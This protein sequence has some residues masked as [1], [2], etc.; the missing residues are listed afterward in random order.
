MTLTYGS[1][2]S[3][4]EAASLA[5]QPLGWRCAF[6]SE[7]DKAPSA[8]LAQRFPDVPNFGDM[9]K[10][11]EWPD[12]AI[13]LLAGGTPC[14]AFSV[15]G[16][17]KGLA[18]PRGSLML[19]Y[20]AIAARY[21]PTWLVWENVPGVL[22]DDEGRSFG[23]FL[24]LLSGQSIKPPANGW[25]NSGIIAP[26]TPDAYGLAYA[27]LDAQYFRVAQRRARVFVVGYLGDWRPPLAVLLE[28]ES[29]RGDSPPRREAQQGIAGTIAGGARG[30]GGYSDDD[31][32][33]VARALTAHP[34]RID[35]ESETFITHALTG[36]GFDASEDGTGRGTP[37]V[38]VAYGIDSDCFDR[39]GEGSA[40]DAG[41]R[42]GLGIQAELSS[43]VRAKRPNAVAY[44]ITPSQSNKDYKARPTQR[45]QAITT[46]GNRPSARGGDVIAFSCKDHGADAGDL[47]PTLRAMGHDGSHANAG[48]QAAV[49]F[50][51]SRDGGAW[52][53]GDM[54]GTLDT[55][56]D[57]NSHIVQT[58]WAVRRLTPL[59]CE[60]LQG[61]PDDWTNIAYRGKNTIADGPR[62]KMIGNSWAVPVVRWIGNRIAQVDA[63][64][65]AERDDTINK[66]VK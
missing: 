13:D 33:H 32:P 66:G 56:T 51:T 26:G 30:R 3:G 41:S 64:L 57:P 29:L 11:E 38:P 46:D 40:A 22:S 50:Q 23:S 7:I 61:A 42:S 1:V 5:W 55:M 44:N 9:T 12:V 45:S 16:L 36:E 43:V 8:L 62:Y 52:E 60:R 63:C 15:A 39:S 53:T 6:V 21:R 34:A 65:K 19:V 18:D 17:R 14:Q 49:A 35:S 58:Q 47:S 54:T 31:I 10:F 2:C 20:G 37:I 24:G 48:G 28:P 25:Q 59:E 4:M 27:V